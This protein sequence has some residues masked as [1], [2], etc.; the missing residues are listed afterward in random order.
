MTIGS[1]YSI[2]DV[3]GYFFIKKD[4]LPPKPLLWSWAP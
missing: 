3:S 2:I 1:K 4:G